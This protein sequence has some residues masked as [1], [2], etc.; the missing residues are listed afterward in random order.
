MLCL[1]MLFVQ[2]DSGFQ[3]KMRLRDLEVSQ[4]LV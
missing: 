1:S 4:T 2:E 3:A